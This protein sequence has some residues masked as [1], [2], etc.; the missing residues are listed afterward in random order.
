MRPLG[1]TV[2][3]LL[4]LVGGSVLFIAGVSLVASMDT[5]FPTFVQEYSKFLNESANVTGLQTGMSE[6]MMLKLYETA[7]YIAIVMGAIYIT[8][9]FGLFTLREWGRV[10]TVLISG[11]NV[12]YSI[13][14]AFIQPMAI[15]DIALNLVVI[16][17]LMRPDVREKFTRKIS[18]EERILGNQNP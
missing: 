2:L 11:F 15:V 14:L 18:I 12:I 4:L 7:S 5:A 8:A 6:D 3:S 16:W 10:L 17:Y 1:V 9:G 13:F